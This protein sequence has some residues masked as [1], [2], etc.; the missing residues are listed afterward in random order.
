MPMILNPTLFMRKDIDRV[1]VYAKENDRPEATRPKLT[2]PLILHP[3]AAIIISLF[4]G[5]REP[6]DVAKI[7]SYLK[8][9]AIEDAIKTVSELIEAMKELLFVAPPADYLHPYDPKDFVINAQELDLATAR[10]KIPASMLF[11]PT[12]RCSQKCVY[13]Y[14][15]AKDVTENEDIL[16][17]GRVREIIQECKQLNFAGI[18]ISGGEPFVYEHIFALLKLLREA[19]YHPQIPTKY[20]LTKKQVFQLKD[21][22]FDSFQISIDSLDP[23]ILTYMVGRNSNYPQRIMKTIDYAKEAGSKISTVSVVTVYNI[24]TIPNTVRTLASKGNIFRMRITEI[25]R[26]IYRDTDRLIPSESQY[27]KLDD[28]INKIKKDFPAVQIGFSHIKDPCFMS[29]E[30]KTDFF[31]KR[32]LCSAGRWAFALLPT[33]KVAPCEELYYHPSFIVG[34]LRHQSIMEMWNSE[35]FK[36]LLNPD[37]TLFSNDSPCSECDEFTE[38]HTGKG[39][40]WKRALKAYGRPDFPDPYCPR[41][42]VGSRIC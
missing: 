9:T 33:G 21:M 19:G 4:D 32:A 27:A 28:E 24:H 10:C 23:K 16:P 5:K 20:P 38:C 6:A 8:D 11:V 36:A 42:P 40:C 2:V 34:D 1:I 25:A 29:K 22:G 15:D 14:A 12:L 31:K 37:K 3:N 18:T 41:A 39:R 17:F 7:W 35:E 30:E 26:S 13:C